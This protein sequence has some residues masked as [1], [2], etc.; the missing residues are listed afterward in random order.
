MT[1]RFPGLK[2]LENGI[3][4]QFNQIGVLGVWGFG[5]LVFGFFVFYKNKMAQKSNFLA[6]FRPCHVEISYQVDG[7]TKT[8]IFAKG[9]HSL[10]TT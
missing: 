6:E 9:E 5:V 1:G 8:T 3:F 10:E 2:G 7:Q 4:Y